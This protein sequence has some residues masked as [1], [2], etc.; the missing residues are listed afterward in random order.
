MD[1]P[2]PARPIAQQGRKHDTEPSHA[3]PAANFA[4]APFHP[5]PFLRQV[6]V[7]RHPERAAHS[8]L[9]APS[10][11]APFLPLP[12]V[13]ARHADSAQARRQLIAGAPAARFGLGK[14]ML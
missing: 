6:P 9:F 7:S 2:G 12:R 4:T 11:A 10:R 13:T 14:F 3:A 8:H 1:A 5:A